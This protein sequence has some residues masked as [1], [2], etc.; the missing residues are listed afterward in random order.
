MSSAPFR[1]LKELI[2]FELSGWRLSEVLWLIF[3]CALITAIS[4][5]TD[6]WIGLL[7][8]VTGIINVILN[9]KGKL[10]TYLFGIINVLLYSCI[11]FEAKF[12]GT[13][14][15]YSLYFLPMNF[16]GFLS[17][18]RHLNNETYEVEKR[19][20]DTRWR[21]I[22]SGA[23]LLLTCG[24]GLILQLMQGSL[25]YLD[26]LITALSI[27]AMAASVKR[28]LEQWVLWL[29]ADTIT[30]VMWSLAYCRSGANLAT[31]LMWILFTVNGAIMYFR[32]LAE[33]RKQNAAQTSPP[34]HPLGVPDSAH[35]SLT[36]S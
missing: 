28:C 23:V 20:A 6:T 13:V 26:A 4:W 32:W 3:C 17:W 8:A 2:H 19:R 11:A 31:L 1:R 30:V 25:P 36:I 33:I 24:G 35:V 34:S 22:I 29:A 14:L 27:V 16:Y 21:W 10:S 15:L 9:G 18:S 7:S 5:R 12:Y